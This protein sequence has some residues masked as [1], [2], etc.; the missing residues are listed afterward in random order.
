MRTSVKE[1][2]RL[3]WVV[4]TTT[5][6]CKNP[7]HLACSTYLHVWKKTC[8]C[9]E[10]SFVVEKKCCIFGVQRL[11]KKI[12]FSLVGVTLI[13]GCAYFGRRTQVLLAL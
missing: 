2:R 6:R 10:E 11:R 13:R 3:F 7:S 1:N 4:S 5:M 9:E 12:R 8:G